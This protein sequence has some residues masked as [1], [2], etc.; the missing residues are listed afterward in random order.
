M[1]TTFSQIGSYK[2][3]PVPAL[4]VI[5]LIFIAINYLLTS[6]AAKIEARLRDK[7]RATIAK[8]TIGPPNRV[9]LEPVEEALIAA[10]ESVLHER[11]RTPDK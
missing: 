1:L 11:Y 4:I 6:A 9:D 3:N 5:A 2:S 8:G 7:G 10:D